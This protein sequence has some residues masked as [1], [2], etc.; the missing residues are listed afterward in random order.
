MRGGGAKNGA[1][2]KKRGR[3]GVGEKAQQGSEKEK[4][5]KKSSPQKMKPKPLIWEIDVDVPSRRRCRNRHY[6]EKKD[7]ADPAMDE[8]HPAKNK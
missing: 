2:C 7:T 4:S 3:E 6:R 8:E 5:N 1:R